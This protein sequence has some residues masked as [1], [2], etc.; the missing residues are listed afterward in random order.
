[1]RQL[2]LLIIISGVFA[3]SCAAQN[4]AKQSLPQ[5]EKAAATA[6]ASL[7]EL[8]VIAQQV[9]PRSLGFEQKEQIKAATLGT[10]VVDYMIRLDELKEYRLGR[11]AAELLKAT[12]R[13]LYPL[14]VN[15][16]PRSSVV[17]TSKGE[18]WAVESFGAT[19]QTKMF[20][21]IRKQVAAETKGATSELFQ[22]RVPALQ[23]M[24]VGSEQNG[25]LFFTPL[26]NMPMYGL[27][28]GQS[29]RAEDVVEKLLPA[30]RQH[31]GDPT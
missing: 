6:K 8:E 2:L 22:V 13:L 1:M 16:S 3:M 5:L 24:F 15:G 29:Y 26:Y 28:E 19:G 20:A 17:L 30:A 18:G 21:K 14:V 31:N 12:G 25:Q 9:D 23:L 10:P 7:R 27:K 11:P 4:I